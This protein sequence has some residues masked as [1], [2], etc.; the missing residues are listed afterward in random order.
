[1]PGSD[2][3]LRQFA[4]YF[5][6]ETTA[7]DRASV[8]AA[9]CSAFGADAEQ[10]VRLF[11]DS[12]VQ[13]APADFSDTELSDL[14]YRLGVRVPGADRNVTLQALTAR[15][16]DRLGAVL[17][18][19]RQSQPIVGFEEAEIIGFAKTLSPNATPDD[20]LHSAAKVRAWFD[21]QSRGLLTLYRQVQSHEPLAALAKNRLVALVIGTLGL[22][23]T[24]YS[25]VV[26]AIAVITY[27]TIVYTRTNAYQ[28]SIKEIE[29]EQ[30]SIV[31]QV[32]R[33]RRAMQEATIEA[34]RLVNTL[35]LNTRSVRD[36]Q[37][38]DR[39]K[40]TDDLSK[41]EEERVRFADRVQTSTVM[42]DVAMLMTPSGVDWKPETAAVNRAIDYC[43][44]VEAMQKERHNGQELLVVAFLEKLL[45][46]T[47][48]VRELRE[49][50]PT[51][52]YKRRVLEL[53]Q[54]I[55]SD[56][57]ALRIDLQKIRDVELSRQTK[58]AEVT[59]SLPD[60]G[61]Y[62]EIQLIPPI[63]GGQPEGFFTFAGAY[64][65]FV[66]GGIKAYGYNYTRDHTTK[67][68]KDAIPPLERAAKSLRME[69]QAQNSLGTVNLNLAE[70]AMG[71]KDDSE[72]R[73]FREEA[74]KA[75]E[76]ALAVDKSNARTL[77]V[78]QNR[79]DAEYKLC[80][81]A[82]RSNPRMISDAD[83]KH[84]LL[85]KGQILQVVGT[86]DAPPVAFMTSA[87]IDGIVL[88]EFLLKAI[89][90]ESDLNGWH[91]P[92]AE[93][94][95]TSMKMQKGAKLAPGETSVEDRWR[96]F[97]KSVLDRIRRASTDISRRG[98]TREHFRKQLPG[99]EY[100]WRY[101]GPGADTKS[102][103]EREKEMMD[104]AGV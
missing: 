28:E 67:E 97:Y 78:N 41:I 94:I 100:I 45:R 35:Q 82:L 3:Q 53:C 44:Q 5:G 11:L 56:V 46:L 34:S 63:A 27:L 29:K 71:R 54:I 36:D 85:A 37:E 26:V 23:L 89:T 91:D 21:G 30:K 24:V 39:K 19:Y 49:P 25:V 90:N 51:E 42:L 72:F 93:F 103:E 60:P 2:E 14:A 31:E 50:R 16:G 104:A 75:W 10:A 79:V 83:A 73:R 92:L 62:D 88:Q 58:G 61:S 84:G 74:L 15:F 77:L 87:E 55:P 69:W 48:H 13:T 99:L 57:T 7:R 96:E 43:K 33:E 98:L 66:E 38:K 6:L 101:S 70:D 80:V 8:E 22:N 17:R 1:M 65:D 95:R 20:V 76:A 64:L 18:L 4:D 68:L 47:D 86:S 32:Q 40:L 12:R 9:I 52:E 59:R 102:P 81:F